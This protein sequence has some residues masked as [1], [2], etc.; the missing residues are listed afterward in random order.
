MDNLND[1]LNLSNELTS[2][3]FKKGDILQ[4]QGDLNSSAYFVKQ[5]LLRS[6]TIDHKGKEHIFMFAPENWII[7][8]IESQQFD[9]PSEL[10]IE[11]LED[12]EVI[13]LDRQNLV[14]STLDY[15]QF[16]RMLTLLSRRVGVLQRRIIMMMSATAKERY[17]QFIQSYP[18]LPGRVPQKMIAS[19]LGITPEALSKIR[20]QIA[21][22]Q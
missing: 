21:R 20:G 18:N 2:R 10:Y 17:E 5:G 3:S 14:S 11:C 7:S 1:I 22:N 13:V 6:Y 8:D 19:H 9:Q 4:S 15:T 16:D 12:S